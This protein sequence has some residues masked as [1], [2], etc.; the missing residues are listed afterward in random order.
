VAK[1]KS[2]T[3]HCWS[4][5]YTAQ[6]GDCT[7]GR[8]RRHLLI[9]IVDSCGQKILFSIL[10]FLQVDQYNTLVCAQEYHTREQVKVKKRKLSHTC[11]R[12]THSIREGTIYYGFFFLPIGITLIISTNASLCRSAACPPRL[13]ASTSVSVDLIRMCCTVF[14]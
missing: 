8:R 3:Q 10:L 6:H 13:V 9:A 5:T 14:M 11:T 1:R 2:K 12:G 4:G 7:A